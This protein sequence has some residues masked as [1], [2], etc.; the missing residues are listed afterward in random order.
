MK[1]KLFPNNPRGSISLWTIASLPERIGKPIGSAKLAGVSVSE[2]GLLEEAS[3]LSVLA[4]VSSSKVEEFR[5]RIGAINDARVEHLA[6][7][8]FSVTI[9]L[10]RVDVL[11]DL[12]KTKAVRRIQTKKEKTL[13]LDRAIAEIGLTHDNLMN[14]DFDG[15][16]VF[17][18]VVDSGFDLSHPMFR[19]ASGALRVEAL[20]DQSDNHRVYSKAQLEHRWRRGRGPGSD[21]D[22]HGTHVASIAAGS[23]FGPLRGVAPGARLLLVK[24][25]KEML[26]TS[27]A[28]KW[29]FDQAGNH[30]C[31]VNMSLGTH[32]GPHDGTTLDECVLEELI[33]PGKTIVV[34][35]GN[36]RESGIH[37]GADFIPGS[38]FDV[39]LELYRQANGAAIATITTWHHQLDKFDVTLVT[40]YGEMRSPPLNK[41]TW[42]EE[43]GLTRISYGRKKSS[44]NHLTQGQIE[45]FMTPSSLDMMSL[46]NWRLRVLCSK[47][48]V[49]RFDAWF[50]S[51]DYGRFYD[52]P[53][54]DA[55][56]SVCQPGTGKACITVASHVSALDWTGD[57]G[58][59]MDGSQV[60]GRSSSSSGVGPT[61][62]GRWKPEI[63]APGRHITAA[64][65]QNSEIARTYPQ[66]ADTAG[67]TMT[68][69]GTSMATPVVAGAIALLLQ[70]DPTLDLNQIIQLFERQAYLDEFTGSGRWSP[71]YGFGKL[72]IDSLIAA[73]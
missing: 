72:R 10:D 6:G 4:E 15:T 21:T 65:A 64:L 22:G 7:K 50:N 71:L 12:L 38:V 52:S 19:E 25:D 42:Y 14:L 66:F 23:Q 51:K 1:T 27:D 2:G 44:E 54:V 30:P 61:R 34:S 29:I 26:H 16:G 48:S 62:D 24:T 69:E 41:F 5:N 31:V 47:A 3:Q 35:A 57:F 49:G 28:V 60:I 39:P 18:G 36:E 13:S 43:P 68:L 70:K 73:V 9:P 59:Q 37:I 45:I 46:P 17:I 63:S 58:T 53:L 11:V 32:F 56:R 55:T 20:L 33:G 40:P 67:R 8:L